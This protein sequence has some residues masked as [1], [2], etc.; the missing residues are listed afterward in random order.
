MQRRLFRRHL[1][2]QSDGRVPRKLVSDD[3]KHR[4]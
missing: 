3:H 4:R 1:L 2:D